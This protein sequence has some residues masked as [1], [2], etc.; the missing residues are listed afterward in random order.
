M[1]VPKD[2]RLV[3]GTGLRRGLLTPDGFAD[4]LFELDW[5]PVYGTLVHV[6]LASLGRTKNG[7][8]RSVSR[9]RETGPCLFSIEES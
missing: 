1:I 9:G 3:Y 2:W 5:R 4:N 6:D 8:I 7:A